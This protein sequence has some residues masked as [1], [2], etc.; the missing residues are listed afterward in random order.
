MDLFTHAYAEPTPQ[1]L[2]Q[3]EQLRAEPAAEADRKERGHDRR[4]RE[5]RHHGAGPH[6]RVARRHD[7]RPVRARHGRGRR[8]ARRR[9]PDH[10]RPGQGVRAR[11]AARQ[12]AA[13]RGGHPRPAVGMAC[14]AAAGV[15]RSTRS[16]TPR[17]SSSSAWRVRTAPA[18][19]APPA[20]DP[21][22]YGGGIGGVEHHSD[23]SEAYYMATPG[24]HVVTPATV[25]DAYGLLRASIALDD[26]VVFL[27]PKRA[28]GDPG[29]AAARPRPAPAARGGRGGP[30]RGL[31]PRGRRPALAGAVRRREWCAPRCGDGCPVVHESGG[32][33][34][35]GGEHHAVSRSAAS[36]TWRRRCCAWP[37][38]TCHPAAHAGASPPARCGPDPGRRGA[39]AVG[40]RD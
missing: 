18:Q 34:G 28:G 7:R 15:G 4:R 24:L 21:H 16:P 25:A 8:H 30:G 9:L 35:P 19:D 2:E 29:A 12:V 37:G 6:A 23:A 14:R 36:T 1:L 27:E 39:S 3:R 22:P 40:G 33:G 31:G 20:H 10:G 11:T 5:A 26:P 38:S 32:F 17:S 13:G